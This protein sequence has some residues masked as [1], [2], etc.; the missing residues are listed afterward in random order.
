MLKEE[1]EEENEERRTVM[2]KSKQLVSDALGLK[3]LIR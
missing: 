1:M 2:K 3:G